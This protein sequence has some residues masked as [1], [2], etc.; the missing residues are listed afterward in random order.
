MNRVICLD[1]KALPL[2]YTVNNL[3][4]LEEICGCGMDRLLKTSFSAV[5]GLLWCGLIEHQP[6]LTLTDAGN[7]LEKHLK[8]G[9]GLNQVAMLLSAALEDAGFFH[10][11][12]AGNAPPSP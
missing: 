11:G 12:E 9:A 7:L 3:C 10:P 5:R 8:Q 6:E 4:I 1:G 2:R